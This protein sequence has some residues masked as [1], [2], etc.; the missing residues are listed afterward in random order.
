M[1]ETE[2]ELNDD[3]LDSLLSDLESRADGG[4]QAAS[5]DIDDDEAS[6]DIEAFLK[7]LEE[8]EA[9]GSNEPVQAK[10]A[11]R[12]SELDAKF[13]ELDDLDP[14]DL[15]AKTDDAKSARDPDKSGTSE[16]DDEGEVAKAD[17]S[18][19][20][21]ASAEGTSKKK[22]GIA[23]LKVLAVSF[24]SLLF[25]WVLG[26][27]L[28]NW[29]SAAWLI[30]I[31]SVSFALAIPFLLRH[32]VKKGKYMWWAIG[33]SIALLAALV[34]PMPGQAGNALQKYGHWPASV[35]AEV[36]GWDLDSP[37]VDATSVV[38]EQIGS[39]LPGAAELEGKQLGTDHDLDVPVA[40]QPEAAAPE[41]GG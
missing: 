26:A 22:F 20:D 37:I 24:P 11:E 8:S 12:D 36:A 30:G 25:V 27:F 32:Y 31:I 14:S 19:K 3:E 33:S 23:A 15:P 29:V 21:E 40:E 35:V 1:S 18:K 5:P 10:T 13:A 16:S 6:E 17:D 41:E 9:S 38:S 2:S 34:A 39:L 4:S 7:E 28:G